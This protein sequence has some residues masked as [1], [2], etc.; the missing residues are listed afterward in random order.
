M[1]QPPGELEEAVKGTSDVGLRYEEAVS[2][3]AGIIIPTNKS[4]ATTTRV[5]E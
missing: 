1:T 2:C 3:G 5:T 4:L